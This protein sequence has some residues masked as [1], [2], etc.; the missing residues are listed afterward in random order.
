MAKPSRP[1]N[2]REKT[3]P[4]LAKP[5]RDKGGAISLPVRM[6]GYPFTTLLGAASI[7][8]ILLTTWWVEGMRVTLLAGIPWLAFISA[9]YLVWRRA[10][11]SEA[12]EHGSETC[13]T[14]PVP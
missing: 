6:P 8:A 13:A 4:C 5:G 9:C 11:S 14:Q 12:G 1:R 2:S 7:V 10:N 3:P